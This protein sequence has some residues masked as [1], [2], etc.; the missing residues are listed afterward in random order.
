LIET[1]DLRTT[2]E[3]DVKKALGINGHQTVEEAVQA[4]VTETKS[5]SKK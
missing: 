1:P 2:L 4:P 3:S 5:K